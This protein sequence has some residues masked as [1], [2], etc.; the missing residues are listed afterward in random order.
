[1]EAH[2]E[3]Y[4]NLRTIEISDLPREAFDEIYPLMDSAFPAEEKRSLQDHRALCERENYH[5]IVARGGAE[6]LG[7]LAYWILPDIQ[8]CF[9]EHIAVAESARGRGIGRRLLDELRKREINS[10]RFIVLEIEEPVAGLT[11]RRQAFYE[12]AAFSLNPFAYRQ[13]PY[14]A[15]AKTAYNQW[16]PLKLMSWPQRLTAEQAGR[17]TDVVYREVYGLLS[18]AGL[19]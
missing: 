17:F 16:L 14:R 13:P 12:R 11:L 1:M 6:L 2:A 4:Q 10:K 5:I 3:S 15:L 7:F 19:G 8:V 9:L 18:G